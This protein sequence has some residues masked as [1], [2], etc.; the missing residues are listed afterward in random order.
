MGHRSAYQE[1]NIVSRTIPH[2]EQGLCV[3]VCV[4]EREREREK[5]VHMNT[6]PH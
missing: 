5:L 6:I 2:G 4:Y 3:C 1:A